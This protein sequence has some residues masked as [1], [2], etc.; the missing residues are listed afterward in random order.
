M[1][2]NLI[3]E[4]F[5]LGFIL[6]WLNSLNCLT[7]SKNTYLCDKFNDS[8]SIIR[9]NISKVYAENPMSRIMMR[10]AILNNKSTTV[11]ELYLIFYYLRHIYRHLMTVFSIRVLGLI[12]KH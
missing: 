2:I 6:N 10:S 8:F 5:F 11:P 9:L 3:L 12:L 1:F 7:L 4:V